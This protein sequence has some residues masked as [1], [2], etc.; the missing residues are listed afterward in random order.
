MD[1]LGRPDFRTQ[2]TD[3][4]AALGAQ[5]VACLAMDSPLLRRRISEHNRAVAAW[6]KGGGHAQM[7]YLERMFAAKADP[8][9]TFPFARSIILLSFSNHW[10]TGPTP[11]PFPSPVDGAPVGYLSAYARETDYHL[12]GRAMLTALQKRLQLSGRSEALVDTGAVYE[13]LF[14]AVAGLGVIGENGLLRTA[15]MGTRVFLACLFVEERLPELIGE[16]I[17]PFPCEQCRACL[18]GCPTAAIGAGRPINAGR[19][20]SYLTIEKRDV[21]TREEARSI[22]SWIFGCDGCTQAC[23]PVTADDLRVPVDLEWLLRS[24]ASEIRRLLK[25]NAAA[26][27]GVTRLRRNAV[28]VLHNTGTQEARELLAWTHAHSGSDLILRQIELLS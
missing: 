25:G 4:A 2:L 26:Y 5:G 27:A 17:M 9:K 23:P 3:S 1:S 13:R 19:C 12:S 8:W 20:I 16:A 15:K 7:D 24:P 14:A 11:H 10:G 22:G 6:L 28:A 21:L 18:R